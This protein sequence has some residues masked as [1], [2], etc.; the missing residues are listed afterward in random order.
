MLPSQSWATLPLLVDLFWDLSSIL[1]FIWNRSYLH[2]IFCFITDSPFHH[3]C[4]LFY[5]LPDTHN[6]SPGFW[7]LHDHICNRLC[8]AAWGGKEDTRKV[9]AQPCVH[10]LCAPDTACVTPSRPRD[11]PGSVSSWAEAVV[12][13]CVCGRWGW[14]TG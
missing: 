3:L 6:D 9:Y 1:Y 10:T 13:L 4:S 2:S 11:L 8:D 5:Y 14:W 12:L 7:G